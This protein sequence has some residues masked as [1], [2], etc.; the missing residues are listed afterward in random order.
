M[1]SR[2]RWILGLLVLALLGIVSA[3][4]WVIWTTTQQMSTVPQLPTLTLRPTATESSASTLPPTPSPTPFFDTAQAGEIAR[5]VAAARELLPRWQTPLT[6]INTY[7]LSVVLYR[8][9]QDNPPFPLSAQQTLQALELWPANELAPDP[10]AQSQAVAA[11]YSPADEQIYLRRDWTGSVATVADQVAYGYAQALPEQHGN[12][13][14]LREEPGSLDRRLALEAVAAGDAWVTFSR[15][16]EQPVT[17]QPPTT[18]L[19]TLPIWPES[20]ELSERLS[21]LPWEIGQ[22][23]A[24]TLYQEN[25]LA[26]LDEVLQRPPQTTEQLLHPEQYQQ[27]GSFVTFESLTVEGNTNWQLV[28][29]E[30][31]GEA[32]MRLTLKQW[33][34]AP[35]TDTAAQGWNGDLLQIWQGPP[36]KK[37]VLWQT[38]WDSR[39]QAIAF[40]EELTP[41]LPSRIRD[42][43]RE[44]PLPAGLPN[45]TWW[46]NRWG[47]VFIYRYFDRVWLLWGDDADLV[48]ELAAKIPQ[49]R[50]VQE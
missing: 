35:L 24:A 17:S 12:L 50:D 39:R 47:A 26:A 34:R 28:T 36:D 6:F 42:L 41:L 48:A 19:A 7:D 13:P 49:V 44:A 32:I 10:V 29:T 37:I 21:Q 3:L 40:E 45:G 8:R 27:H 2:Q 31:V 11:L 38:A 46:A 4:S 33:S 15:Y 43:T 14:R 30:T 1:T 20:T 22:K 25:G 5:E 16:S 9:H 23:F 18:L